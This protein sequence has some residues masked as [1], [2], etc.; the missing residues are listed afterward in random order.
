MGDAPHFDVTQAKHKNEPK[1]AKLK[2][3]RATCEPRLRYHVGFAGKSGS[4]FWGRG[5]L[6]ARPRL[7]GR[8]K[9]DQRLRNKKKYTMVK[10]GSHTMRGWERKKMGEG[11]IACFRAGGKRITILPAGNLNR[12]RRVLSR[13]LK[14][15]I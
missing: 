12:R 11:S 1:K 13:D 5:W 3:A 15:I 6:E 4:G 9:N 2:Y 7:P 14:K 8:R 10:S